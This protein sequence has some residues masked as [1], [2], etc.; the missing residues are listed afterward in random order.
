MRSDFASV[1]RHMKKSILFGAILAAAGFALRA[2][3]RADAV[4]YDHV[5]RLH[6]KQQNHRIENPQFR[7]R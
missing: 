7:R 5:Q 3:E 6:S 2:S 1:F 4:D